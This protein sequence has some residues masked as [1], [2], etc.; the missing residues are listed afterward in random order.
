MDGNAVSW[1]LDRHVAEGHGAAPAFTD[2]YRRLSYAALAAA[3]ARFAGALA[4]AGIGP[5][6]RLLVL[7]LDTVDFP[8]A[9]WGAIRAGVVPVP[10]TRCWQPSRWPTCWRT[11]GPRR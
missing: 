10:V 8:V 6:Q 11:A 4:Q 1:F 5:E 9:F 7:L 2:P 3:S